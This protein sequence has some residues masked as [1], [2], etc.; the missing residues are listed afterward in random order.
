MP[1]KLLIA[2]GNRG[3]LQEYRALLNGVP[4]ELTDLQQEKID[5]DVAEEGSTFEEN[6]LTKARAYAEASGLLTVADDSG[7]EVDALGGE[8]GVYSARYGGSG[9][10]DED[11]VRHLLDTLKDVPKEKRTARFRCVIV[12]QEPSGTPH[13]FEGTCEGVIAFETRGSNGFGYDP[14]FYFP[15]LGATMAELPEAEKNRVSH[16][17]RAVQIALPFLRSLASYNR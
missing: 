7:L 17:G 13:I 4:F 16:R 5:I 3:K 14:V 1:A 8:P 6:A 10:S 9:L 2:T 11:R 15:E 12:V